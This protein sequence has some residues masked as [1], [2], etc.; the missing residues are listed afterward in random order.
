MKSRLALEEQNRKLEEQAR[1]DMARADQA[2][3]GARGR[4]IGG[5]QFGDQYRADLARLQVETDSLRAARGANTPEQQ[6]LIDEFQD[7][8][9]SEIQSRYLSLGLTDSIVPIDP[10]RPVQVE[11]VRLPNAPNLSLIHI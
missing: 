10:N 6:R 3:G 8:R 11:V 2:A 5:S 7:R 4:L 1:R 9:I